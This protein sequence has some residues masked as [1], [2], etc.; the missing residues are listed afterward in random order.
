MVVL[1]LAC[2]RIGVLVKVH[3]D[4]LY[5]GLF[6]RIHHH[7]YR[8]SWG[9]NA[10]IRRSSVATRYELAT[11]SVVLL[12]CTSIVCVES[13]RSRPCP[14]FLIGLLLPT[15][16]ALTANSS[17]CRCL[18]LGSP[19]LWLRLVARSEVGM[20]G[21]LMML[22]VPVMAWTAMLKLRVLIDELLTQSKQL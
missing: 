3:Q 15:H 9:S 11:S 18:P 1:L 19:L 5:L 10:P 17:T 4:V 7:Y 14:S 22:L 12:L 20:S 6:G 16:E 2:P 21:K 13:L 8:R